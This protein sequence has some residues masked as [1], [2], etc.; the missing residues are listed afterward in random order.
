MIQNRKKAGFTL[1]E[2]MIVVAIIAIIASIA[3][4]RLISARLAANESAAIA[5]LRSLSS[6]Q[7]QI[8]SSG[9]IDTDA[10][11]GGE[12]GYFG[13]L[14]GAQ[15]MRVSNAGVP[16]A[17]A[18]GIDELNPSVLS[19]AF[20]NVDG[21]GNVTRS[22]YVYKIFLPTNGPA[23]LG[24][25][26]E[27]NGGFL[28][29]P[30]PDSDNGEVLWNAYAWPLDAGTTGNRCFFINQEGDLLSTANRGAGGATVYTGSAIATNPAFNAAYTQADMASDMAV[31][32]PGQDNN[33]WVLVQ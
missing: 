33:T 5:A 3:I 7:A 32:V 19:Q 25:G 22:G 31:G 26:E 11:G 14:S 16:A 24:V 18:A 6:A 12:F 8:Q 4:P 9:A 2:L 30:F 13:E 27:A 10:D 17:G 15:P 23:P 1:I 28:A 20:G 21:Q 29:G